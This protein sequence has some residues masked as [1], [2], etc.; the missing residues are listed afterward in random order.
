MKCSLLWF[1]AATS[2]TGFE[3]AEAAGAH[4]MNEDPLVCRAV[5][6][7][8]VKVYESGHDPDNAAIYK[9]KFERLAPDAIKEYEARGAGKEGVDDY[10]QHYVD[11]FTQMV[12]HDAK[13]LPPLLAF[14]NKVY[15]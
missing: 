6:S 12:R 14:C 8:V 15:P 2:V 1:L 11:R 10:V 5:F 9:A 3:Y 13:A 7:V 4:R